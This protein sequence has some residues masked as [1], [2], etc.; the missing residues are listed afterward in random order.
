[1]IATVVLSNGDG[2][3][4]IHDDYIDDLRE[5][6]SVKHLVTELIPLILILIGLV[7]MLREIK[8][9]YASEKKWK[10][11]TI[12][13]SRG[14]AKA[15]DNTIEHTVKQQ[16][17]GIYK[18]AKPSGRSELSAYFLEDV[19]VIEPPTKDPI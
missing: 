15:I 17:A 16:S 11:K 7:I 8:Q 1:M 2:T 12:N 3:K 14:L 6:A 4:V 19:L 13:L 9:L 18:K 5:K 10:L